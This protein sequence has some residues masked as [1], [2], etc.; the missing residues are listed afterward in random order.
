MHFKTLQSNCL[1]FHF[2][3]ATN[4]NP[5]KCCMNQTQVEVKNIVTMNNTVC[6]VVLQNTTQQII[7]NHYVNFSLV[8]M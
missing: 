2:L 5:P 1:Q 4:R 7:F 6:M 8:E 3:H